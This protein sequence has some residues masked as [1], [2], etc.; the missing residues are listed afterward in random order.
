MNF[1]CN[2]KSWLNS[3]KRPENANVSYCFF[4]HCSSHQFAIFYFCVSLWFGFIFFKNLW[5]KCTQEKEKKHVGFKQA[6]WDKK[7]RFRKY[8]RLTAGNCSG[9]MWRKIASVAERSGLRAN[10]FN[11][12][13]NNKFAKFNWS[14]FEVSERKTSHFLQV[15]D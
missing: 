14:C 7:S 3:E 13:K 12:R 15:L 11:K 9:S 10:A 2:C 1:I 4:R 6:G 5:Q 8:Y